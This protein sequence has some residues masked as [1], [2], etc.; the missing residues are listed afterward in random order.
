[1]ESHLEITYAENK[2]GLPT[3]AQNVSSLLKTT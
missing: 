2:T 1:M 3:F